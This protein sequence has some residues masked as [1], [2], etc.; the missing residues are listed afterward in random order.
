VV[1]KNRGALEA[2]ID[3]SATMAEESLPA[4][5]DEARSVIDEEFSEARE[6][7]VSLARVNPSVK[8]SEIDALDDKHKAII[9]ALDGTHARP[10]SVRI[11]FNS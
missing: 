7:L 3:K 6:R 10:V 5:V 1:V 8:P 2:L 9:Q 11:I 4:L